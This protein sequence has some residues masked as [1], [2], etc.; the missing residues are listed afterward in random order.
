M[1]CHMCVCLHCTNAFHEKWCMPRMLMWLFCMRICLIYTCKSKNINSCNKICIREQGFVWI[2]SFYCVC[3]VRACICKNAWISSLPTKNVLKIV[4]TFTK[5]HT[6]CAIFSF[7][8][9]K[10]KF[11]PPIFFSQK[12][13][14]TK[15]EEIIKLVKLC[16]ISSCLQM[17]KTMVFC[18][19]EY[20]I[21]WFFF[22]MR[23]FVMNVYFHTNSFRNQ[24]TESSN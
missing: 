11:F 1:L 18:L 3:D 5:W 6:K 20:E 19:L 23:E 22:S 17:N 4:P 13:S 14:S 10:K 15:H 16:H 24:E 9:F 2:V 21:I 7:H 12:F 8:L